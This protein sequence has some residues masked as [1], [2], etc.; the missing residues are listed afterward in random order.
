MA[1]PGTLCVCGDFTRAITLN[2][3][4]QKAAEFGLS[5]GATSQALADALL[6]SVAKQPGLFNFE[7]I[8]AGLRQGGDGRTYADLEFRLESCKG[9]IVEGRGGALR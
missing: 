6:A 2:V 3:S 7:T 5:A 4:R 1:V 8:A 9:D